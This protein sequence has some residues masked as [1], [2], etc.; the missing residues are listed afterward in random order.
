MEPVWE[1]ISC[2]GGS[3]WYPLPRAM[4]SKQTHQGKRMVNLPCSERE[5][6]LQGVR[7]VLG[8]GLQIVPLHGPWQAVCSGACVEDSPQ[9]LPSVEV[10]SFSGSCRASTEETTA[11]SMWTKIVFTSVDLA[12]SCQTCLQLGTA[13]HGGPRSC[14]DLMHGLGG[15][16][17]TIL[18]CT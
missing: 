14:S 16:H 18:M 1:P 17:G 3:Q 5:G 6:D 15:L 13:C 11:M 12:G 9:L 10:N 2:R 7:E 4:P 8:P